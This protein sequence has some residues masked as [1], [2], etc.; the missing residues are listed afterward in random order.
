MPLDSVAFYYFVLF[1]FAA[2]AR[3][4]ALLLHSPLGHTFLC[5]DPR[6]LAP[7]AQFLGIHVS[8][9][10]SGASFA[11]AGFIAGLAGA[12]EARCRTISSLRP[13]LYW[14]EGPAIS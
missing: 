8:S 14:V 12:L 9:A 1:F 6:E 7:R 3:A 11:I 13:N 4:I 2:G 10:M 5:R